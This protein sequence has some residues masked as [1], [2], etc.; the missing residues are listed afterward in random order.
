MFSYNDLDYSMNFLNFANS[1]CNRNCNYVGIVFHWQD[2]KT[3]SIYSIKSF[4]NYV[5][6]ENID[7]D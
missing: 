6:F 5:I 2:F 1:I 4:K 7:K 3:N